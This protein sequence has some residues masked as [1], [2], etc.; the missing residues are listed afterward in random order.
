[1]KLLNKYILVFSS[2]QIYFIEIKINSVI[3]YIF[4]ELRS[5]LYESS[6]KIWSW[7]K[8][9]EI[10]YNDEDLLGL[11]STIMPP[12]S[13]SGP[14]TICIYHIT[15]LLLQLCFLNMALDQNTFPQTLQGS[16][17]PSR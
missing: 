12:Q 4:T 13:I 1:M 7:I 17:T 16:D 6:K 2:L 10:L 8:F 15:L 3:N 14:A 5:V 11:I 9:A